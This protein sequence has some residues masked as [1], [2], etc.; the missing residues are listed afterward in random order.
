MLSLTGR[1]LLVLTGMLAVLAVLALV[2][3]VHRATGLPPTNHRSHPARTL[4]WGAR[5]WRS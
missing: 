5:T 2:R 3:L 4:V 1:P